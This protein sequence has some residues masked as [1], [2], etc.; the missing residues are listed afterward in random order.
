MRRSRY[1][2]PRFGQASAA[3]R[4]NRHPQSSETL[5]KK[6]SG[7]IGYKNIACDSLRRRIV[8]FQTFAQLTDILPIKRKLN[9]EVDLHY[10][11]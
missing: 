10:L 4:V 8:T 2:Q 1:H 7:C 3:L 5:L 11:R 6:G 9:A